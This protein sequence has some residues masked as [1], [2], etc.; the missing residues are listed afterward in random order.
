M[1]RMNTALEYLIYKLEPNQI[2]FSPHV[3]TQIASTTSTLLI[4]NFTD[5]TQTIT[6]TLKQVWNL[7]EDQIT[8]Q[9]VGKKNS[10]YVSLL[11]LI[12]NKYNYST[13][14]NQKMEIIDGFVRLLISNMEL[15][16]RINSTLR[17]LKVRHNQIIEEIKN[18]QYQSPLVIYYVSLVLDLNIVILS[19]HSCEL[20]IS[21]NEYDNC[22][23]HIILYKDKTHI[24]HPMIYKDFRSSQ[25]LT[26]NETPFIK[27][28]IDNPNK[29]VTCKRNYL[30]K[31]K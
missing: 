4:K 17:D 3:K 2:E 27:K 13:N 10:L 5:T 19:D 11:T 25:Y 30:K 24:Y 12:L 26:Y 21:D 31:V 15:N 6:K 8:I 18:D 29:K 9:N 20:F 28:L 7:P 14:Y 16:P 1:Y 23:P 22:K